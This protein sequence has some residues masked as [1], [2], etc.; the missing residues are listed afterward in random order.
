MEEIVEW[1]P[2]RR[3]RLRMGEFSPPLSRL[4]TGF[5]ETLGVRADRRADE[6]RPLASSCTRR[7]TATRP[8]LWLISILLKRA[9]ARHLR[10]MQGGER[11][12]VS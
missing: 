1:E 8:L 4:A 2:D 7:S 5:D 6:G 3:L 11:R 9:I 10:Q 12:G